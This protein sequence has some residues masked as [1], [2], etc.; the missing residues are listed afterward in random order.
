MYIKIIK[1]LFHVKQ[2][3]VDVMQ[4]IREQPL[5]V[6]APLSMGSSS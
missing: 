4:V 3:A 1:I 2:L 5:P 6:G